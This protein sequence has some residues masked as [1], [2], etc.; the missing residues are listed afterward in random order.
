M[1][2]EIW[3]TDTENPSWAT[4]KVRSPLDRVGHKKTNTQ[5]R[6]SEPTDKLGD[7]PECGYAFQV[8]ADT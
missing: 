4:G 3:G 6:A 2:A 8:F 1:D 5:A 7:C